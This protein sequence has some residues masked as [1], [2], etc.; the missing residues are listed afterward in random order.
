MFKKGFVLGLMILFITAS[1]FTPVSAENTIMIVANESSD[2]IISK[3]FSLFKDVKE[4]SRDYKL[5]DKTAYG[6]VYKTTN[7]LDV[8][9]TSQRK[10][11]SI[12]L[13]YRPKSFIIYDE[14]FVNIYNNFSGN[15]VFFHINDDEM[16]KY[17][18]SQGYSMY[19]FNLEH[20]DVNKF[21]VQIKDENQEIIYDTGTLKV[22]H[23]RYIEW[24]EESE[25]KEILIKQSWYYLN[26]LVYMIT[27][28]IIVSGLNF[29]WIKRM[30]KKKENEI[31]G[32]W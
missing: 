31:G 28:G 9:I 13:A 8:T 30:K 6:E 16:K 3:S 22:I 29:L 2:A 23:K 20:S 27:G 1:L 5:E 26:T 14:I 10:N 4:I 25:D 12:S 21:R 24:Y 17:N 15:T 11:S 7:D 18:L 32:G 19:R